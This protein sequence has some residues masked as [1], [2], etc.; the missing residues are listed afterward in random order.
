MSDDEDD[1]AIEQRLQ[2]LLEDEIEQYNAQKDN[3]LLDKAK[4]AKGKRRGVTGGG[5]DEEEE[6]YELGLTSS[7][8]EEDDE[9]GMSLF[10]VKL[11]RFLSMILVN[12]KN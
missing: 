9:H 6:V 10:A 1:E 5:S 12:L 8:D 7:E 11:S 4:K 3:A 2:S